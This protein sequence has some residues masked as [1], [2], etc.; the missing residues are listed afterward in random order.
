MSGSQVESVRA[1]YEGVSK[2]TLESVFDGVHPEFEL[3]TAPQVPN[4]GTYRGAEAATRFFADLVE[5]F[6]EV[7]YV[8]QKV[9]EHRNQVV[10]FVLARFHLRGSTSVVENQIGA[11]WTFREGQPVRCEMFPKREEA[12]AAAGM[13]E[14]DLKPG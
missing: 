1:R 5:P 14:Q 9:F 2:G 6:D 7:T 10:I 12:L 8:P 3:K 11:L 13:T 4:A